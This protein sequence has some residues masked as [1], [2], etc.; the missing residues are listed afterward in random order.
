MDA[1]CKFTLKVWVATPNP[2]DAGPWA[3]AATEAGSGEASG[4][5]SVRI[6]VDRYGSVWIDVDRCGA[7]RITRGSVWTA[8][9][10]PGLPRRARGN[11]HSCQINLPD[12]RT[13]VRPAPAGRRPLSG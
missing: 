7:C 10:R 12:R 4:H 3:V 2:L 13:A 9:D 6:G 8:A 11:Q 5:G 1:R